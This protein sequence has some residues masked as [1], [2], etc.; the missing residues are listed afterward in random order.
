MKDVQPESFP[1]DNES[2]LKA[3]SGFWVQG[4]HSLTPNSSTSVTTLFESGSAVPCDIDIKNAKAQAETKKPMLNFQQI[5]TLKRDFKAVDGSGTLVVEMSNPLLSLGRWTLSFP[6]GSSHSSHQ[7]IMHPVRMWNSQDTFTQESVPYFWEPL[8]ANGRLFK[9]VT[10]K[11]V[12][13]A[14]LA[15]E[16]TKDRSGVLLVDENSVDVI[17]ALGTCFAFLNRSDSFRK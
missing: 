10:G 8:N 2:P 4:D 11:R 16:S 17:V 13:V 6:L 14:N 1:I 3:T 15:R 7:I 5:S 9:V 12:E